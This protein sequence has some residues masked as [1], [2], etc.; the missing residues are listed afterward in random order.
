MTD[1]GK[2]EKSRPTFPQGEAGWLARPE[3]ALPERHLHHCSGHQV[4]A[5][6]SPLTV[7]DPLFRVRKIVHSE[8][9]VSTKA[10][11]QRGEMQRV[12]WTK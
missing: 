4:C 1:L 8:V 12:V 6:S 10:V 5:N 3:A 9:F 11:Q 2:L 7:I